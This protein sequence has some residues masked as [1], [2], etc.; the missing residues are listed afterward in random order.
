MEKMMATQV[1]KILLPSFENELLKNDLLAEKFIYAFRKVISNL[2]SLP[3]VAKDYIQD[4]TKYYLQTSL[5]G[6]QI[7]LPNIDELSTFLGKHMDSLQ[8]ITAIC[9]DVKAKFEEGKALKLIYEKE[10]DGS[11]DLENVT[12]YVSVENRS[13]E[14]EKKLACLVEP[15]IQYLIDSKVL[16]TVELDLGC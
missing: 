16:F 10:Q 11:T 5:N 9:H 3:K 8:P 2:S 7:E 12:L 1:E 14:L 13:V 4:A 15:Y 6:L